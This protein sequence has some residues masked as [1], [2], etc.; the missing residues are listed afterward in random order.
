LLTFQKEADQ[1]YPGLKEKL[2][3]ALVN[4]MIQR[5]RR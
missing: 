3:Y 4:Y 2:G 1:I 5:A